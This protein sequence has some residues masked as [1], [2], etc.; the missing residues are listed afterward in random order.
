MLGVDTEGDVDGGEDL[1]TTLE[2]L[3]GNEPGSVRCA[4]GSEAHRMDGQEVPL[5]KAKVFC[6]TMVLTDGAPPQGRQRKAPKPSAGKDPRPGRLSME[7][8]TLL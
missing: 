1:W 2:E 8:A 5:A 7:V 6:A 3:L 4:F